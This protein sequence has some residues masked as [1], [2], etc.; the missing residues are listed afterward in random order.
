M[1]RY[2]A[3]QKF[4][5]WWQADEL[6]IGA[7]FELQYESRVWPE[8]GGGYYRPGTPR[9]QKPDFSG[10]RIE[11]LIKNKYLLKVDP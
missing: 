8:V 5:V 3:I 1:R 9:N 7:T 6:K 11:W 10:A 4:P 2:E